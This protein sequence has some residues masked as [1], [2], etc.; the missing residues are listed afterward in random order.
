VPFS[1][2]AD[3]P[4][5]RTATFEDPDGNR[6]QLYEPGSCR[7]E[8]GRSDEGRTAEDAAAVPGASAA[9]LDREDI[10]SD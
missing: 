10:G 7:G 4:Y 9:I 1:G 3:Q 6:F 8:G 2:I 5:G